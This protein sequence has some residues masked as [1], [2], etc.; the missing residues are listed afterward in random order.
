MVTH[1]IIV[2]DQH[3]GGEPAFGPVKLSHEGMSISNSFPGVYYCEA[4]RTN[5]FH[6][7]KSHVYS[8]RPLVSL[9]EKVSRRTVNRTEC[10]R[11]PQQPNGGGRF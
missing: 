2:F 8:A 6:L 1:Q 5:E 10:V 7:M 3:S 11:N 4:V 9:C